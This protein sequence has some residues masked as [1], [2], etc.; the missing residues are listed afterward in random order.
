MDLSS[1]LTLLALGA[2]WGGSF[3]FIEIGLEQY[4]PLTVVSVRVG[5]A[6]MLLNLYL[7]ATGRPFPEYKKYLKGFALLG[8][9]NN[10]L[11]F[12]LIVWGQTH[13]TGGLASI[14]NAATP[15]FTVIVAAFMTRDER[16][17]LPKIIAL[18][19]GFFGVFIILGPDILSDFDAH[20][21]AQIA[22]LGASL[23]YAV[24][25]V[26]V[27][28]FKERGVRPST[29]ASAQLTM[30]AAMLIPLALIIDQ[31]WREGVPHQ[32][33][34]AALLSLAVFSTTLAYIAYFS[35]VN[36]NGA[37]NMSLVTFLVPVS[38]TML[39]AAFLGEQLLPRHLIG[40]FFI[41]LCFIVLD[42]RPLAA[43]RRAMRP[44]RA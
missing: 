10:V 39:G 29:L 11:P 3:F 8:L 44:V 38:A 17:T 43:L 2:I 32:D 40:M 30:S 27:R 24:T 31:P 25:T 22:V 6:A 14:L 12:L 13:I 18:M 20:L 23:C 34:A 9:G 1:W 41:G 4:H 28:S 33:V 42:G 5:L 36:K 15:L 37:T 16:L 19:I 7:W 21:L 35:F 26:Y